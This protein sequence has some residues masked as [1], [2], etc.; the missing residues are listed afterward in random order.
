[1]CGTSLLFWTLPSHGHIVFVALIS[2]PW[3]S[4]RFFEIRQLMALAV[5]RRWQQVSM[6][7]TLYRRH[8]DT[9]SI[10]SIRIAHKSSRHASQKLKHPF[11]LCFLTCMF[12]LWLTCPQVS[13]CFFQSKRSSSR[14]TRP[15]RCPSWTAFVLRR[16]SDC[17]DAVGCAQRLAERAEH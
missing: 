5:T 10:S 3:A 4:Q 8:C 12:R 9:M 15:S 17:L 16:T 2:I 11:I 14:F 1:M 13:S 7:Q 6:I